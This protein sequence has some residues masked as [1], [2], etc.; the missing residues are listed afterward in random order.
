MK[1]FI[2]RINEMETLNNE[3]RKNGSS[4]VVIYGRRRL[5]KTTLINE[6]CKGKKCIPFLAT[7]EE[8]QENINSFKNIVADTLDNKLLKEANVNSWDTVFDV[9][10]D[11]ADNNEKLIIV[12]DEF[13]YLGK[14]NPAFPSILQK[15]WDT[16]LQDK[17]VMLII[18]GSLIRMMKSQV[19]DYS[20][21]LYGR[22]T[23]QIRMKQ[24]PF[25]YYKDFFKDISLEDQIS[26]Y[27]VT[28]G[29]PK[30]IELFVGDGDIR[31]LIKQ[32]ILNTSSF[33]YEEPE[34]L[35][36]NEIYEV[37]RYFTILK[38]I[39]SGKRKLADISAA[40][41]MPQSQLSSYLKTL[42]E[43]DIV[44]R[45]VPITEEN[46]EKSKMG[47][48][49]ITDNYIYFWFRF[50]YPYR[51]YIERNETDW[52]LDKIMTSI[53]TNHV[54][55]VYEDIC[56]EKVFSDQRDNLKLL[57]IGKWWYKRD[58]EIEIVGIGEDKD[59]LFGEC[60][61]SINPKGMDVLIK[62]MDQ[63]QKVQWNNKDRKNHYAIFSHSG[64]DVDLEKYAE[65]HENVFLYK[66]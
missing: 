2:D 28:G 32:N 46:P 45:E 31:D 5:G 11:K 30:Y 49:R 22:R 33:L 19:L 41:E 48:Y 37:G 61:Y 38:T 4:F 16:K 15:I 59:I 43:L 20:S 3:Y 39:A 14:S 65:E 24:I 13:Q 12:I 7:E 51:A 57:R 36:K 34:F 10:A 29:V 58:G 64:F 63:S 25:A 17:N 50:V 60:K 40:V 8:E 27:A 62:L 55:F 66:I 1:T 53:K 44:T 26:R 35:L 47:L 21:A 42:I 6:F 54:S 56:R 18:C 9:I 52:V 23:S